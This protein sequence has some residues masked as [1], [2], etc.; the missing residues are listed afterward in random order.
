MLF[1]FSTSNDFHYTFFILQHRN[2]NKNKNNLQAKNISSKNS[3]F[4]FL[5]IKFIINEI[6]KAIYKCTFTFNKKKKI[7]KCVF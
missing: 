1:K 7:I 3:F 5:T 2:K 4:T 6:S